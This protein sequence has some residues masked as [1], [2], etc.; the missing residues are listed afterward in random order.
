ML[1]CR[2]FRFWNNLDTRRRRQ[3]AGSGARM[4]DDLAAF[5][6]DLNDFGGLARVLLAWAPLRN[7]VSLFSC[8]LPGTPHLIRSQCQHTTRRYSAEGS[9]GGRGI[10]LRSD[11]NRALGGLNLL[12]QACN[13]WVGGTRMLTH[14]FPPPRE[15][16]MGIGQQ[17]GTSG[18]QP[19][20]PLCEDATKS[21]RG[22]AIRHEPHTT[23][24]RPT[25][26]ARMLRSA[27]AERPKICQANELTKCRC[28]GVRQVYQGNHREGA[29]KFMLCLSQLLCVVD[30]ADRGGMHYERQV[31]QYK[32]TGTARILNP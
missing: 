32:W 3:A 27:T 12:P 7:S 31:E 4:F 28:V 23:N 25:L 8:K 22:E 30:S 5:L 10:C 2:R 29:S 13:P 16:G 9:G 24:P 1:L 14:L 26:F 11:T 21:H 20:G 6:K 18:L 19:K 15:E 17:N